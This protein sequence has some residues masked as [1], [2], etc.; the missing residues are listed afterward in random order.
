MNN[1]LK[2]Y[3]DS[4]LIGILI[5]S[6]NLKWKL[7]FFHSQENKN[8]NKSAIL[9][10]ITIHQDLAST[11]LLNKSNKELCL[12]TFKIYPTIMFR[13]VDEDPE[14]VKVGINTTT[15]LNIRLTVVRMFLANIRKTIKPPTEEI[16]RSIVCLKPHP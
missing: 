11:E 5:K 13:I 1:E 16:W 12:D 8:I 2:T 15:H 9:G 6:S 3:G 10:V 4:N 7:V 14:F